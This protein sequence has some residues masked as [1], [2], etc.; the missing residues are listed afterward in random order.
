MTI[1][2][3]ALS[4]TAVLLGSIHSVWAVES[5]QSN[6][7]AP[8]FQQLLKAYIKNQPQQLTLKGLQQLQQA[9]KEQ[10][11][12]WIAGDVNVVLHHETD[13]LTD[14]NDSQNWQVGAALPIRLPSQRNTMSDLAEVYQQRL[15]VETQYLNW[16]ASEQL[17]QLIWALQTAQVEVEM[18]ERSLST[19]EQLLKTINKQVELGETA[20]I[21]AV[22]AEQNTL[23]DEA[24]LLK[25]QSNLMAAQNA[26]QK[27]TGFKVLPES[28]AEVKATVDRDQHPEI[29]KLTAQLI[30]ANTQLRQIESFKSGQPSVYFGAQQDQVAKQTDSSLVMEVVIPLGMDSGFAVK[31]AEQ[32]LQIQQNQAALNQAK[33]SLALEQQQAEHILFQ[34]QQTIEL[35]KQQ[36]NL[37]EQA[38]DMSFKA[39]KLGEISIQNLLQTQQQATEARRIDA[40][41]QLKLGQAIANYNQISGHI[42][43]AT[44]R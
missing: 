6:I 17:R 5:S 33:Q 19:S 12:S 13:A 2:K 9:Q 32:R 18:A 11:D 34:Q 20:K 42:L 24:A 1:R 30:L 14:D 40:M 3:T 26:Y 8:S 31:K 36:L 39:Y 43:G 27:W 16:L 7:A 44:N 28:I 38:L 21:D 25:T 37:A 29:R 10:A 4:I 41:A 15:P 22:L 35:T 23:E